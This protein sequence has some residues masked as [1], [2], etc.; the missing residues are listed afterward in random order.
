MQ[1]A[2]VELANKPAQVKILV[3]PRID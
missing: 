1:E 3:D 2:F